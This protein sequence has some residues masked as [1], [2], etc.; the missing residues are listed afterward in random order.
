MS[1]A[2]LTN[3]Y[4][5]E[6]SNVSLSPNSS[7]ATLTAD[8][9]T[10]ETTTDASWEFGSSSDDGAMLTISP[11]RLRWEM[12]WIRLYEYIILSTKISYQY[13]VHICFSLF[14]CVLHPFTHLLSLAKDVTLGKYTVPTGNRTPGCRV[15]FHYATSVPCKL[16]ILF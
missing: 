10:E 12:D 7:Q 8:W 5:T 13:H 1:L 2:C 11:G 6:L 16:H 14:V 9:L 3:L 4:C 15:A